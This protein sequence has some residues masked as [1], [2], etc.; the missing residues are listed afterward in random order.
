MRQRRSHQFHVLR[1]TTRL[2]YLPHSPSA[3]PETATLGLLW[4]L[5]DAAWKCTTS[6]LCEHQFPQGEGDES[7]A[8]VQFVV[9][10]RV[11]TARV[12]HAIQD[13][14]KPAGALD[15]T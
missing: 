15:V 11:Q 3:I 2:F 1:T 4:E 14:P 5:P 13:A 6:P 12:I 7:A 9:G 10:D 8:V